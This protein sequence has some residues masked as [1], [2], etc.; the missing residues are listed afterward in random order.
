MDET[1]LADAYRRF[2]PAVFAHCRRLLP[3]PALARDAAQEVFVKVLAGRRGLPAGDEGL[4]YLY[5]VATNHCLNQLRDA[6]VRRRAADD[7]QA[8]A[9]E[10]AAEPAYAE[11]QLIE[12][13]LA[14]APER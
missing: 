6:R 8:H 7:L 10:R 1:A 4:R 12:K 3:S 9:G 2:A 5:R 11:R 14:H 13:L